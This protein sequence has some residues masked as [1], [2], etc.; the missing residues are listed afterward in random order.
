MIQQGGFVHSAGVVVQAPGDSQ[1]NGKVFFR[2]TESGQIRGDGLQLGK[3]L[4]KQLAFPGVALQ[5]GENLPIGAGNGDEFQNIVSLSFCE[6]DVLQQKG[7]DF[8]FPDLI[9]FVHG[10]HDIAALL[11]Q[12]Q[13]IIE[14][15]Q[16][17]PV[18]YPDLEPAQAEALKHL[19]DDG[20][21]L[22][23]VQDVQLAIADDVDVCLVEF[24][25]PAPLG[26]LA[27]V[28][29]ADLIPT[30]GESQVAVVQG[31]IFS[32]GHCQIEPK[33]QVAVP[34][35]EAVDLLFRLAAALGEENL[36]ILDDRGVQRGET[37]GGVG[38]PEDLHHFFKAKLLARQQFHKAGQSPGLDDIHK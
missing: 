36:G 31:H 7:A 27:P 32:K 35:L 13:H 23:L 25:E 3:A 28:D 15:V 10:T 14:A 11:H 16:N 37:I 20:G 2:H 4:I 38:G 17:L 8:F 33:G 18:V 1:V 30:E 5:S 12:A 26:T 22:R 9:Q 24:P 6:T 19:I 34:L 21:N 29:L